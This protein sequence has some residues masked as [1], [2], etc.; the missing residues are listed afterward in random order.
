MNRTISCT[1][2]AGMLALSGCTGPVISREIRQEAVPITGFGDVRHNADKFKDQTII[3]GGKIVSVTN[4]EDESTT[5]IVL[6]FPLSSSERPD[7]SEENQGRFMVSTTQ[8]LD[9][10]IYARGRAV[11]VAG[12]VTGVEVAPVGKTKYRYVV[13]KAREI[14]LWPRTPRYV[15]P[16]Y[17]D[18]YWYPYGYY[19]YWGPWWR[20]RP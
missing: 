4:H 17:P 6:A 3:V 19:D 11:T 10:M 5:L 1:L 20:P 9:P 2:I 8:F 14:Y 7:E 15:Y 12:I 16:V 18:W 13:I